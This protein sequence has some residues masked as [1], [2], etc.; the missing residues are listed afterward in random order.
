MI[1]SACFCQSRVCCVPPSPHLSNIGQAGRSPGALLGIRA[2]DAHE[3][4]VAEARNSSKCRVQMAAFHDFLRRSISLIS[5]LSEE[6]RHKKLVKLYFRRDL[7]LFTNLRN[8]GFRPRSVFDVGAS[9]SCWSRAF[10]GVFPG[11]EVHM[12]E[13]LIDVKPTFKKG[14]EL[15]LARKPN[16]FLHKV[17]LGNKEG[18]VTFYSD[19]LGHGASVLVSSANKFLP[20]RVEGQMY[21]IDSFRQQNGLACPDVLKIDVQ[22]A[23]LDVL[24]GAQKSLPEI[25]LV[26]V[27]VWFRRAYGAKTPLFHEITDYLRE[28]GFLLFELGGV[29]YTDN[30]ELYSCDSFF[31][32]EDLLN[33]LR[34]KV[35]KDSMAI[36]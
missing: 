24:A 7:T 1:Q 33:S 32:K 6:L 17:L 21:R 13:P 3:L 18:P 19:A 25:K 9:N 11:V 34:G 22:G 2:A 27:E 20:E 31:A 23:E 15:I 36:P 12:F 16:F 14:C 10:E 29:F 8:A 35:P 26:E 4:T 5:D 30:H 28:H